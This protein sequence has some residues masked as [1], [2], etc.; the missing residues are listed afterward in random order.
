MGWEVRKPLWNILSSGDFQ[1]CQCYENTCK[2]NGFILKT[3]RC[4]M[5]LLWKAPFNAF[6]AGLET[7][8]LK[9]AK[10]AEQGGCERYCMATQDSFLHAWV[11]MSRCRE[12][13]QII[14]VRKVHWDVDFADRGIA[15]S[16]VHNMERVSSS[17]LFLIVSSNGNS[18]LGPLSEEP[19]VRLTQT[20]EPLLPSAADT[21]WVWARNS[22]PAGKGAGWLL[23]C[24]NVHIS[25]S[26]L[27]EGLF[28]PVFGVF[29]P[30]KCRQMK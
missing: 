29:I 24:C 16:T 12:I 5:F 1:V 11:Y 19:G 6:S 21:A 17:G 10:Q 8:V 20:E 25:S 4:E 9:W 23:S 3:V 15:M 2:K 18:T 7:A 26:A 14:K 28:L 27:P 30:V 13:V 22:V